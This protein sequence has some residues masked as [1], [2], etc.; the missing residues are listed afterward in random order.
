MDIPGV[1]DTIPRARVVELVQSLGLDPREL[2]SC[3]FKGRSID[4]VVFALD[5]QGHR[6]FDDS[7]SGAPATHRI[8]IPITD[9]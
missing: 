5:E 6:Y 8:S 2:V 1:P 4:A 7:T 3:E 9:D